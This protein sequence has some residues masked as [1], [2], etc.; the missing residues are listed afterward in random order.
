MPVEVVIP[1]L[2]MTMKE[3]TIVEWVVADGATVEREQVLYVLS[4]DKLDTDVE[5][6]TA[7]T[8]HHAAPAG[9][10]HPVGAVVGWVLEDGEAVPP[11]ASPSLVTVAPAAAMTAATTTTTT[12]S[13]NGDGAGNGRVI[14]SPFARRLA[15]ERGVEL[16]GIRGTGPR[17]R[18]VAIDVPDAPPRVLATPLARRLAEQGDIDLRVVTGTGPGGRITR[19]DVES[20]A[21][22]SHD[23]PAVATEVPLT[24]MRRV[25]A[26]RMHA[27]L[28][29]MAQLTIGM[30]V[31]VTDAAT[32]RRQLVAEWEPEGVRVTYTDL[33][34][35]AAVKALGQHPMLN[36]SIEDVVIKLHA[37]VHLGVAVALDAGLVVPVI[38]D[39]GSRSLHGLSAEAARLAAASR[40]GSVGIDDLTGA[41]FTVSTLG[42]SG[43]D[44]FTPVINPPN[45]AI[46]GVGRVHDGVAWDGDRPVKRQVMTL[47]LTFDH[48]AIDGAP[49]AAFLAAVRDLL[50]SPYRLLV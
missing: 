21:A 7:G 8:L 12:A 44:F 19:E 42:A 17:G 48:R 43:V 6:E 38:R 11:T 36:A 15:R 4:T 14:A 35:R 10:T 2:G 18:I 1:K 26:E 25:I 33:V 5:A 32:L 49:A 9:S 41:T 40:D 30:E 27:S 47:S 39:A 3:G 31:D 34:C 29:E 37:G 28:Q 22:P 46:L 13:T 23:E 50:E 45:V 24:G 20:V 16:T